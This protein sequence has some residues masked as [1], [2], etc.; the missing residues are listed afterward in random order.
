MLGCRDPPASACGQAWLAE[1]GGRCRTKAPSQQHHGISPLPM[2]PLP[3]CPIQ[4]QAQLS[5][6]TPMEKLELRSSPMCRD[7][8]QGH[9][10]RSIVGTK[11]LHC[12][13]LAFPASLGP[14]PP[15]DVVAGKS[16]QTSL[17]PLPH[18]KDRPKLCLNTS[19]C[20]EA[21]PTLLRKKKTGQKPQ[22]HQLKYPTWCYWD[23]WALWDHQEPL[24]SSATAPGDSFPSRVVRVRL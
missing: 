22:S 20:G 17:K 4:P 21:P 1:R 15:L 6:E 9:G 24:G 3:S 8:E 23:D 14:F 10:A 16:K 2:A 13:S 12:I 7:T 5:R 18:N 19:D 11:T